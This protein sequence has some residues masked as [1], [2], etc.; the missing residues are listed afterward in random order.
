MNL[1]TMISLRNL[2]RQKR[3]NFLLGIAIALGVMILIIAHAFSNGITDILFNR[4]LVRVVGHVSLVFNEKGGVEK[5]I[6]RDRAR[7]LK[8]VKD[9]AENTREIEETLGIFARAI[10]NGKSDSI[11][12]VAI[13][14]SQSLSEETRKEIE[15]SF[16]MQDGAF[17]D[18]SKKDVEN[19]IIISEEKAKYLN[20]KKN[21]IIRIRYT[22]VHGNNESA[23]LT[24]VGI[25]KN[26][27][28]FMQGVT[29][30]E[31]DNEKKLLAYKP[32][33]IG[34]INITINNPKKNAIE[35]ANKLHSVLEPDLAV[36]YGKITIGSST[37]YTTLLGYKTDDE[38][39]KIIEKNL[40]II[41]GDKSKIFK[42]DAVL[43][44]ENLANKLGIKAGGSFEVTYK[45]KFGENNT[46]VKYS[47]IAIFKNKELDN[48]NIILISDDK[49][50]NTYYP[51]LPDAASLKEAYNPDKQSSFYNVLAKEWELLPRTSTTEEL[52]KKMKD[53][54]KKKWK[55]TTVDIRTMYETASDIL[56]L[57]YV[58]NL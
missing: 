56:K 26:D 41:D 29:F 6:F 42:K 43:V 14:L 50:Y 46:T 15:E 8:I 30:I 12:L 37:D 13:D 17:T 34:N 39:K 1:I 7:I 3:R 16:K 18:L 53:I 52:E 54:S 23:R 48:K 22:N 4:I 55:A 58:L 38:S 27:N 35:F 5:Y 44:G 40:E 47:A 28:V 21:D 57:E 36:I 31:L 20:V 24:I 33:E 11:I 10:G 25:I 2:F 32:H 9:N 49:F 45:N 19:P 51:N